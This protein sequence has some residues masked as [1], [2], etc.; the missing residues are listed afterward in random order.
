MFYLSGVDI[1]ASDKLGRLAVSLG[2]CK[3][4]DRFVFQACFDRNLPIAVSM[5]GGYSERLATI[6]EAHA[7][8]F[9]MA[10]KVFG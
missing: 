6:I 3:E 5:G 9:R 4:R 8:T 2:G 1:L 7:N 10:D